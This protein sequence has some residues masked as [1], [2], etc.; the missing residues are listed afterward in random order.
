MTKEKVSIIGQGRIGKVFKKILEKNK[1]LSI[2]TF[3]KGEKNIQN[4]LK[5]GNYIFLC[6]PSSSIYKF[7]IQNKK[8]I[9]PKSLIVVLSKGIEEKTK[10]TPYEAVKKILPQNKIAIMTGPLMAEEIQK[11]QKTYGVISGSKQSFLKIKNLFL[12]S[13][14]SFNY[15]RDA[16]GTSWCGI[17][18]NIYTFTLVLNDYL[19]LGLNHKSYLLIQILKEMEKI[20]K[21][22]G[23]KTKTVYSE[24]GLGD[25]VA[26]AFSPYS[27]NKKT[28][29]VLLHNQSNKIT[30]EGL[31]SLKLIM[32]IP[33][34]KIQT[35]NYPILF[36][37]YKIF[38]K[39]QKNTN[40]IN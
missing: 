39:N 21:V 3:E 11:G 33:Q 14:L 26:T 34:I 24:A 7:L 12:K 25:L 28:A 13:N 4:V 37:T 23:G 19:K 6:I 10:K 15:N 5:N 29:Q 27:K 1:N 9:S 35:Q 20:V 16:I 18:K 32:Q 36:K 31:H 2:L 30:S 8:Y 22:F 17:L 38:V 40:F